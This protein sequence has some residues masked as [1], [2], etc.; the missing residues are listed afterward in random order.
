MKIITIF[1]VLCVM[2]VSAIAETKSDSKQQ[3]I[4]FRQSAMM[5]M[6]WNIG[7]IKKQ[8]IKNP[9]SI[10]R[11]EVEVSARAIAAVAN[12]GLEKLFTASTASGKGWKETR[13]KPEF[14]QQPDKV[15]LRLATFVKEANKLAEVTASGDIDLIR[16]QFNKTFN[17][18]RNCHKSFRAKE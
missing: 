12:T 6:R 18:C 3:M 14:F 10:N 8:V 1:V 9:A 16:L 2:S 4:K 17:A 5:F 13:V 15:R 7:K 11:N